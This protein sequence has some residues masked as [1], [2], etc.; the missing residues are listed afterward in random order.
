M[1]QDYL[2]LFPPDY[3]ALG[4][5]IHFADLQIKRQCLQVIFSFFR[6]TT[7]ALLIFKETVSP[8][9]LFLFPPDYIWFADL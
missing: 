2:F 6:Q 7:F 4:G 8:D 1:S 9:Y 5:Q 3:R